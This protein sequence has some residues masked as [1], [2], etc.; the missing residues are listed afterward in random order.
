MSQPARAGAGTRLI[1][2]RSAAA[3]TENLVQ[4]ICTAADYAVDLQIEPEFENATISL[5]GQVVGRTASADPLGAVAV[6][7][8]A[9]K[10]LLAEVGANSRGEFCL[11]SRIQNG[12]KLF[13]D[14]E[15][16]G[17]RMGIPLDRLTARFRL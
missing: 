4:V 8:M 11:V 2:V 12:M 3:D 7:L 15:G 13:L 5:V 6:R 1:Q 16:A 14:M 10:R 9:R 17:L